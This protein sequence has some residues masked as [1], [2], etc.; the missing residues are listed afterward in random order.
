MKST[1]KAPHGNRK[2]IIIAGSLGIV[3]AAG[4]FMLSANIVSFNPD[5]SVAAALMS[6]FGNGNNGKV[7]LTRN[8][9][10]PSGSVIP[11]RS[12]VLAVYD[13]NAQNVTQKSTIDQLSLDVPII[14]SPDAAIQNFMLNYSYCL[15]KGNIYGYG[16]RFGYSGLLCRSVAVAPTSVTRGTLG[17]KVQFSQTNLPVTPGQT[18]AVLTVIAYP[19]YSSSHASLV[20]ARIQAIITQTSGSTSSCKVIHYGYKNKY[21]YSKCSPMNWNQPSNVSGNILTLSLNYG[22]GYKPVVWQQLGKK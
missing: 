22:Y 12:Q 16:Y 2:H 18:S 3:V 9:N 15:P 7:T 13:V 6:V 19:Y 10:S 11:N 14:G 20:A 1:K 8:V 17:Y 4:I 21:G 5:S